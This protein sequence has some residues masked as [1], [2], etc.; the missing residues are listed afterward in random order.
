MVVC[1]VVAP[2]PVPKCESKLD[3]CLIIDSS[4]SIR[5]NNPTDNSYDN[6]QLQLNFLSSLIGGFS[7][8]LDATR[9]GAIVF[10]EDV[11]LA[12]SL[13]RYN[14][15]EEVQEA[16]LN[17]AYMGQ[18]TNTP[19]ALTQTRNQCFTTANG[20]RP[21]AINLAIIVTDGFPYPINRR[22]PAIA[23]AAALRSAG[24][25]MIAIGVTDA[26]DQDF[27]KEMSS[28]P[29][30]EGQNY[31]TARDF[32]LLQGIIRDVV[33]STCQIEVPTPGM[34]LISSLCLC[35]VGKVMDS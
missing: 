2:V 33:E 31:F 20:D 13:D 29:Q 34:F 28:P 6:W 25:S 30:L 18:T 22:S 8:G 35:L 27:L 26:I 19:S 7:V 17:I 11:R 23:E 16:I 9:V 4:G 10:S 15:G 14:N 5:D 21:D 1:L 12:F 32:T 24:A 3:L